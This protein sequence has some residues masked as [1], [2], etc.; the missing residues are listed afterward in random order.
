MRDVALTRIQQKA[1]VTFP[2]SAPIVEPGDSALEKLSLGARPREEY[3]LYKSSHDARKAF[4]LGKPLSVIEVQGVGLCIAVKK[5]ILIPIR[6]K[7]EEV[8][9]VSACCYHTFQLDSEEIATTGD[10]F[11]NRAVLFLPRLAEDGMPTAITNK[12]GL[13]CAVDSEWN[14][15]D[16]YRNFNSL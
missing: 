4:A 16:N 6:A 10:A 5:G 9:C 8:I 12:I 1:D 15:L 11:V 7:T 13:Y 2:S 3:M 14:Y